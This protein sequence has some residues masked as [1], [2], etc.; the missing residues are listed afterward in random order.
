[1][2]HFCTQVAEQLLFNPSEQS[3]PFIGC[4]RNKALSRNISCHVV[5]WARQ[6]VHD[7]L[8]NN[9][10]TNA[11]I[12]AAEPGS[13]RRNLVPELFFYRLMKR[14]PLAQGRLRLEVE[15]HGIENPGWLVPSC[16]TLD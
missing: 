3:F 12:K 6:G 15:L 2:I 16:L 4:E 10:R 7:R 14:L 1:M 8:L 5:G 9:S 11:V 13:A